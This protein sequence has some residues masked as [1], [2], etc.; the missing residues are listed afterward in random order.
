MTRLS[1][2]SLVAVLLGA[3]VVPATASAGMFVG[4]EKDLINPKKGEQATVVIGFDE[5]LKQA[6]ITVKGEQNG[7]E[8]S[9]T[10]YNISPGAEY[11]ISWKQGMGEVDYTISV[12]MDLPH[13]EDY[14]DEAYVWVAAAEPITATIPSNKVDLETK[15]FDLVSNHPP[16]RIE[17]EVMDD[18]R[19][20]IGKSVFKVKDAVQGK[21]VRVTWE[22]Q[23]EGNIF[24][25]SAIAHDDYGYWA[26][27]D[28][29]PWSLV[30]EHEDVNFETARHEV[31]D[32]E[33]PK[34][35]AAWD[36]INKIIEKYGEWVECSLY[37]AGYTD[38][39]G[40]ASSNQG[41][42]QRRAMSLAQYFKNKGATFP[43]Y[44]QGFGESVLAVKTED[45]VD[46]LANRRALYII[47]AGPPPYTTETPRGNWSRLR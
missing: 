31:L 4:L 3:L 38:T 25:I 44:Y 34:V 19:R 16:S 8:K 13:G 43:I 15:S 47:T 32:T 21:P 30:I 6:V 23:S 17:L 28:I 24:K 35:D 11:E 18:E 29:I 2:L 41:L 5:K 22:Q 39:V 42:S 1:T 37:V 27:V 33:A 20:I 10:Y 26:G 40:D 12:F 14:T 9:W 36:E 7:F 46:E 45:S